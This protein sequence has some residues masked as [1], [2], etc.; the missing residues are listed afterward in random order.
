MCSRHCQGAVAG[1]SM[2]TCMVLLEMTFP[3]FPRC[4][5]TSNALVLLKGPSTLLTGSVARSERVF[6]ELVRC[7]PENKEHRG[8]EMSSMQKVVS[9]KAGGL[10]LYLLE[11]FVSLW[12][13]VG[14]GPAKIVFL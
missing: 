9:A 13:E 6:H 1:N 11:T 12:K 2:C 3:A 4:L 5:H 7:S 10:L 14:R 8:G